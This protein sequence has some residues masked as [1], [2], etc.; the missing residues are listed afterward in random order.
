MSWSVHCKALCDSIF[1]LMRIHRDIKF[2]EGVDLS[3][4]LLLLDP[5]RRR[6]QVEAVRHNFKISCCITTMYECQTN[7][8]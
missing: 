7:G 8:R 4:L 5:S 2:R 3:L 1:Q 6:I